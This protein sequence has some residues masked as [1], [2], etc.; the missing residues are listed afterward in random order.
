MSITMGKSALLCMLQKMKLN[1]LEN[2]YIRCIGF[3]VIQHKNAFV[4]GC[5]CCLYEGRTGRLETTAWPH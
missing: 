1:L 3:K 2:T 4:S 5:Y